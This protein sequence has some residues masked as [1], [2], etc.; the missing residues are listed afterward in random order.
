MGDNPV[1][2]FI[3]AAV[4]PA[5]LYWLVYGIGSPWYRSAL[6]VVMFLFATSMAL[7]L[8]LVTWT[9]FVGAAPQPVRLI[10]YASLAL[11]LWAK[12]IILLVERRAPGPAPTNARRKDYLMADL[13]E[14]GKHLGVATDT[15]PDIW[16]K[17]KR[18]VRTIAQALI[19][20][21]PTANLIALAVAGYLTEQVDVV[22]PGWVFAALNGIV[23][24]SAL[25]MGLVARLMAV[26]GINAWLVKVGLGSVP[27]EAIKSGRVV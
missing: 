12:L 4:I 23:V 24:A 3:V 15:V 20:L 7:V 1:D 17:T 22:V 10:V 21:V 14:S 19:V 2:Y 8:S 18:V 26:P 9:V 13:T 11:G 16:F 6:G 25:I 27:A 5:V